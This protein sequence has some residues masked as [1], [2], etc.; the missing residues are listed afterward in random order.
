MSTRQQR[1][2][3]INLIELLVAMSIAAISLTV[4]VPSFQSLRVSQDRSSAIIE[5]VSCARLARSE[6]ALRGTPASICTSSDGE[7]CSGSSDWS[8]GWI[9]FRDANGD[10]DLDVGD[11]TLVKQVRFQNPRFTI[12]GDSGITD[13]IT[14][15]QFGFV[16]P[17]QAPGKIEYKDSQQDR[18]LE[19][20]FI[21]RFNVSTGECS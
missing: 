11:D 17:P 4:G 2:R 14:F 19:M 1:Q 10:H 21:G 8:T 20:T 16:N 13:G 18:C 3:G 12:N 5:L 7:T 15:R 6:A 9:V